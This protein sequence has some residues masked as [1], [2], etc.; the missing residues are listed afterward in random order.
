M[1]WLGL[2]LILF[3]GQLAWGCRIVCSNDDEMMHLFGEG[4]TAQFQAQGNSG[5][6]NRGLNCQLL[7]PTG[8]SEEQ[9]EQRMM[10]L[11]TVAS[12][13]VGV[14]IQLRTELVKKRGVD[15]GEKGPIEKAQDLV[16]WTWESHRTNAKTGKTE[17][18][19]LRTAVF[20]R[21]LCGSSEER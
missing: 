15:L 3:S 21:S 20:P 2:G 1:R 17:V 5:I 8:S 13:E 11:C 4:D 12:D 10:N 19:L 6:L 14:T 18:K 9:E 16:V 7:A